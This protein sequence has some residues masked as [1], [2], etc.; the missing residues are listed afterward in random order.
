MKIPSK[1]R[2]HLC[3]CDQ[4][5]KPSTHALRTHNFKEASHLFAPQIPHARVRPHAR[6]HARQCFVSTLLTRAIFYYAWL[7]I[8]C[9][10]WTGSTIFFQLS[11]WSWSS[12]YAIATW[13]W[14]RIPI[15][16]TGPNTIHWNKR[17]NCKYS[18]FCLN[19]SKNGKY[20]TVLLYC[21]TIFF[22]WF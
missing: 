18:R 21:T 17:F 7:W 12:S 8:A 16:P 4:P 20:L 5:K 22:A 10:T 6:T 13:F 14:T 9:L 11:F 19:W 1:V 3:G 15:W 2:S